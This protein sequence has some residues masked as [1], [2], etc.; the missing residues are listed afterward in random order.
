MTHINTSSLSWALQIRNWDLTLGQ[1]VFYQLTLSLNTY[2]LV[3]FCQ[4]D[5][6]H[7][8]LKRGTSTE[9]NAS[10]KLVERQIQVFFR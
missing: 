9:K 10:I 3:N 5:R 4:V 8:H 7:R 1:Q 6:S 2:V